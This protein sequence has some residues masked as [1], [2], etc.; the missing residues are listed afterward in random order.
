MEEV[1][2]YNDSTPL[3]KARTELYRR[4]KHLNTTEEINDARFEFLKEKEYSIISD[5]PVKKFYELCQQQYYR[6]SGLWGRV[7]NDFMEDQKNMTQ[8]QKRRK[9]T[10]KQLH[11]YLNNL[12]NL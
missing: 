5:T 2:L 8:E 7:F 4:L 3:G 1:M 10:N 9:N 12:Y 6:D 11:Q